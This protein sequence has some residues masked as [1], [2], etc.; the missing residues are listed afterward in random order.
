MEKNETMISISEILEI[1]EMDIE[2]QIPEVNYE[3]KSKH[4]C[5]SA[6]VHDGG[7]ATRMFFLREV[8]KK[9]S[10]GNGEGS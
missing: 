2:I 5:Y 10:S 7:A 1:F 8:Q 9:F 6:G 3:E 4:E